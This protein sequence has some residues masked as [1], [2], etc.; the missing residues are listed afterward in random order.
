MCSDFTEAEACIVRQHG[1]RAHEPRR[2]A[3]FERSAAAFKA[4]LCGKAASSGVGAGEN[5][6]DERVFFVFRNNGCR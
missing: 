4:Y 3:L 1:G 5:I 6:A 2:F